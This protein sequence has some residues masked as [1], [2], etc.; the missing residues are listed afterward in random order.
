MMH[1]AKEEGLV[2]RYKD[3]FST[4]YVWRSHGVILWVMAEHYVYYQYITLVSL[5]FTL[6][7]FVLFNK[8]NDTNN[9]ECIEVN[10][11]ALSTIV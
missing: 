3:G 10:N 7:F 8:F 1:T 11:C 5:L 2:S 4:D 9:R 6:T